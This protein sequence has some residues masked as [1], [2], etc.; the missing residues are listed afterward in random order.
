MRKKAIA[1]FMCGILA[2]SGLVGCGSE[3]KSDNVKNEM[4]K[5]EKEEIQKIKVAC[6]DSYFPYSYIDDEGNPTGF[7]VEVM[8]EAAKRSGY[9][10]EIVPTAWESLFPGLD[11]GKWDAVANQICRTEERE[12]LYNMG[13]VPYIISTMKLIVK[14]DNDKVNSIEDLNGEKLEM[15]VGDYGTTLLEDYLV[16]HPNA[17]EIVY[18]EASMAMVLEN[19]INGRVVG[20][21]NDPLTAIKTAEKNGIS[22]KIKVVGENIYEE[23]IYAVYQKSDKGAE[24]RDNMDKAMEEMIEDGFLSELSVKWFGIDNNEN[25]EDGIKN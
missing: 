9:E 15:T 24:I 4:Q 25:I 6:M 20:N 5:G 21:V 17:F 18:S 16:D 3:K 11:S 10:I 14:S 19:I 1:L 22:D 8:K 2:V 13:N 7:D 12:E 23:C